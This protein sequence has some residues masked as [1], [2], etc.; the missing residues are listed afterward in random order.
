MPSSTRPARDDNRPRQVIESNG[1]KFQ[2]KAGNN[3]WVCTIMDRN[4]Q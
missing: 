2:L 1:I 3:T 4:A